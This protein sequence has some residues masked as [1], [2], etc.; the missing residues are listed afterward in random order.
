MCKSICGA[1]CSNCG[2]QQMCKGCKETGGCPFGE[3]CFVAKY[4]SVGGM[5]MFLEFKKTLMHEFNELHIPGMPTVTE[6]YTLTG[7]F[8]NLEYTLPNGQ[9]VKLLNDNS[10]YLGNQLE[11]EGD[12]ERC[13]GIVGGLDFLVVCTYGENGQNPELVM[14][15][16]R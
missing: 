1:E 6:L 15:K 16:K 3:Q 9:V 12:R 13:Y 7:N 2:M 14:Y 8:V 10:I 4:I 11:C 5:D